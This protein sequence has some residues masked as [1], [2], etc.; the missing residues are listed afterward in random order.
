M[1]EVG[2]YSA[3]S[4]LMHE[5][6]HQLQF[7]WSG[8]CLRF[9]SAPWSQ[10][11]FFCFFFPTLLHPLYLCAGVS[12]PLPPPRPCRQQQLLRQTDVLCTPPLFSVPEETRLMWMLLFKGEILLAVWQGGGGGGANLPPGSINLHRDGE[13]LAPVQVAGPTKESR[14]PSWFCW[15][16]GSGLVRMWGSRSRQQEWKA[17]WEAA[18]TSTVI[19]RSACSHSLSAA[20]K[21]RERERDGCDW[22]PTSQRE[23]VHRACTQ[24]VE[25]K[26][27][28][29]SSS[30][31]LSSAEAAV[32]LS[33]ALVRSPR[34]TDRLPSVNSADGRGDRRCRV[35]T[36]THR[37]DEVW[38]WRMIMRGN[39]SHVD[40][41]KRGCL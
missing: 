10:Q 13:F 15:F 7:C 14:A 28:L 23:I 24:S 8:S 35:Q 22:T 11:T 18:I 16:C 21:E 9:L 27:V 26:S 6:V 31:S 33:A 30:G 12:T 2:F 4:N 20:T 39:A 37:R 17:S 36:S 25:K 19:Y 1:F 29:W 3:S 41:F 38:L 32:R 5:R 34:C 40:Y